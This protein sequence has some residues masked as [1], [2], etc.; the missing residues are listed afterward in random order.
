MISQRSSPRCSIR[1]CFVSCLLFESH[2][3][4]RSAGT[5]ACSCF[6]LCSALTAASRAPC[7]VCRSSAR[8]KNSS[9]HRSMH[10]SCRRLTTKCPL[11]KRWCPCLT[12]TGKR[13]SWRAATRF[14]HQSID[15]GRRSR[16][17]RATENLLGAR[18]TPC[19]CMTPNWSCS[20]SSL[21]SVPPHLASNPPSCTQPDTS[22]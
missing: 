2:R 7:V 18:R 3:L 11:R 19:T 1:M 21:A 4:L 12:A 14:R 6:A 15:R 20:W 22:T 13:W 9:S 17:P 16:S 5:R 8:H 10:R